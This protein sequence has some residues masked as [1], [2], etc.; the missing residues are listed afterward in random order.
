MTEWLKGCEICNAGLCT[1]FDELVE[2]GMSQRKASVFLEKEQKEK[3]GD[4]VYS[5]DALRRRFLHSKPRVEQLAP[6]IFETCAISDLNRLVESGKKFSTFYADP[7]W[8][9]SNQ[10]TRSATNNHYNTMIVDDIALLPI[11]QLS[12]ENAHLHLWTTNAFL[13]ESKKIIEA[14][15]FEYKSCF[16]WV[17]PQ[18][19]IGNYWRLSHEF[20]LF[21]LKGKQPFLNRGQKSWV[22]ADRTKHSSKPQVIAEII[23][24]VSP[25]PYLEL[26]GRKTRT[27]WTVWGDEIERT[28]F[29]ESAFERNI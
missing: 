4:V 15:G 7:P 18:M 5:A 14:W 1:R 26:F 13:F 16:V 10:A 24:K 19:G 6:S 12:N 29:N 11:S 27:N 22:E 28:L 21:G 25:P 23:E 3:I 8:K 20:L 17:K 2:S 9:Y